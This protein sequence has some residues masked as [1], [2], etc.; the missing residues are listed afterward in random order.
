MQRMGGRESGAVKVLGDIVGVGHRTKS[1][2]RVETPP[3]SVFAVMA[4]VTQ[5]LEQEHL[6][7][8]LLLLVE[9]FRSIWKFLTCLI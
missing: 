8:V 4:Q 2:S 9:L 7:W 6:L 1:C 3:L 5:T